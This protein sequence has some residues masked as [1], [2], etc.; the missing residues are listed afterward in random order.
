MDWPQWIMAGLLVLQVV[1][2][3][4]LHGHP[5]QPWDFSSSVAGAAICALLLHA[6]GFWK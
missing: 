4:V 6:G 5:R 3:W 2:G 1:G